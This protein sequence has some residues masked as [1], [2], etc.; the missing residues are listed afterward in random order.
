MECIGRFINRSGTTR[1]PMQYSCKQEHGVHRTNHQPKQHYQT[2]QCS[3]CATTDRSMD[4]LDILGFACSDSSQSQHLDRVRVHMSG[5][6]NNGQLASITF[7]QKRSDSEGTTKERKRGEEF[8][9]G[10]F[11]HGLRERQVHSQFL[12]HDRKTSCH[13]QPSITCMIPS[14]SCSVFRI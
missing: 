7:R 8:S 6:L 5:N 9:A 3:T 14:T 10:A 13:S 2:A 4:H 12:A 1:Q 11:I